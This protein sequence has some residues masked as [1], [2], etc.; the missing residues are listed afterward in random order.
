MASSEMTRASL[1]SRV[2]ARDS[3]A[4][5]ELVDLYGP[6]VAYWCSRSGLDSHASAD[7]VQEVFLSVSHALPRYRPQRASGSFRGWLW[8]ITANKIKDAVRSD[9]RRVSA[10]G[11]STAHRALEQVADRAEVSD[12]PTE[13]TQL[14]AIVARGLA[15]IECQFETKTWQIFWRNV[16]DEAPADIVAGE[17]GVSPAAVRQVRS[18]VLR[19]LRQQLGDVE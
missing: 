9:N 18:R 7:C 16:I 19:R 6:L 1:L 3:F 14:D 11:G 5:S 17:F 10:A 2:R 12:E 13:A 8:T 15:Q 4:W